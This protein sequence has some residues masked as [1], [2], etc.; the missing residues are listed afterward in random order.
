MT[1][2]LA[3]S[4]PFA[5]PDLKLSPMYNSTTGEE[6][7]DC[8][9]TLMELEHCDGKTRDE[10]QIAIIYSR[11]WGLIQRMQIGHKAGELLRELGESVPRSL[12]AKI[13]R[14]KLAFGVRSQLIVE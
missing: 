13:K 9:T 2:R 6:V 1:S 10:Q 7:R 4:V 12:E 14:L 5:G 11:R 3:N 8:P